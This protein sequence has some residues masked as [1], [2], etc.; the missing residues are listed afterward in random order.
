[1]KIDY[2]DANTHIQTRKHTDRTSKTIECVRKRENQQKSKWLFSSSTIEDETEWSEK[3][4][5]KILLQTY[6]W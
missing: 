4:L 6:F 5:E 3:H 1:M 2:E